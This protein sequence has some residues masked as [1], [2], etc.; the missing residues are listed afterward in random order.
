MRIYLL[1]VSNNNSLCPIRLLA[2]QSW[3]LL[4]A[5]PVTLF[6]FSV[7]KLAL[8]GPEFATLTTLSPFLLGF[9]SVLSFAT[10]RA[11]RTALAGAAGTIGLGL[12][13]AENMWVR[14]AAVM[15]GVFCTGIRWAAE[16][17]SGVERGYH[18]VGVYISRSP[19]RGVA[20]GRLC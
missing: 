10:S 3:T 8:A 13:W 17:H 18:A 1:H 16:W 9:T 15:F 11:G 7:W 6:Y 2:Y 14:L 5:L 12:W 4:T 20:E 19:K